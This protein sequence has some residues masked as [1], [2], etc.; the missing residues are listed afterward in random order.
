MFRDDILFLSHFDW[1][2]SLEEKV[3]VKGWKYFSKESHTSVH[4]EKILSCGK[5]D[6]IDHRG[7]YP[8]LDTKIWFKI[9]NSAWISSVMEDEMSKFW[10]KLKLFWNLS[11]PNYCLFLHVNEISIF[12]AIRISTSCHISNFFTPFEKFP[13]HNFLL[14]GYFQPWRFRIRVVKI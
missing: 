14:F 8:C 7:F 5:I 11:F 9:W 1:Q 2:S 13:T 6:L 3:G 4:F 10:M 12:H